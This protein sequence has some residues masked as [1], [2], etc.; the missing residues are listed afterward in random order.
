MEGLEATY[1]TMKQQYDALIAENKPAN[2]P[3]ISALN[4]KMSGLLQEMIGEVT[5]MKGNAAKLK[6]YRDELV[7]KLVSVQNDFSLMQQQKDEYET[8]TLLQT[9]EQTVFYSTFFWYGIALGIVAFA[10]LIVLARSGQ[11]AP[12]MPTTTMSAMTRPAFT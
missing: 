4:T 3:Q 9:H 8:L 6:T 11:S 1:K 10:F 7:T 12:T 5:K 2:L